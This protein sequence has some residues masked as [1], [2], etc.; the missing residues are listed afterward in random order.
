LRCRK[1]GR[2][3]RRQDCG[4]WICPF[5]MR[6]FQRQWKRQPKNRSKSRAYQRTPT[7]REYDRLKKHEPKVRAWMLAYNLD[8]RHAKK[9]G[10]TVKEY[11]LS[12]N[13]VKTP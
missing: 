5:C 2:K 4:N 7:Y 1:C 13:Y 10:L 6:Q 8:W 3:K 12:P 9:L 11:R